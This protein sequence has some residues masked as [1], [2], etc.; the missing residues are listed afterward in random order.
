M[1]ADWPAALRDEARTDPLAVIL[2]LEDV[3][4]AAALDGAQDD[5]EKISAQLHLTLDAIDGALQ[6]HSRHPLIIGWSLPSP[7]SAIVHSRR[8]SP[9]T[10]LGNAMADSLYARTEVHPQ[11]H[12]L[13]LD[14]EFAQL[15]TR[16][17]FDR[18][19]F[20]MAGCRLS[21]AGLRSWWGP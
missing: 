10:L 5:L 7:G 8:R 19:N 11:L 13:P 2:F 20:F 18:R 16:V 3:I 1:F 4:D 15:G 9:W 17:A 6:R 14:R 21:A 12:L